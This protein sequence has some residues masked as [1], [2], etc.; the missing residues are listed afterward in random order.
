[1]VTLNKPDAGNTNWAGQVNS[2]WTSIE[3][4]LSGYRKRFWAQ[5]LASTG[6]GVQVFGSGAVTTEGSVVQTR[7]SDLLYYR[8]TTP[9]VA[10][11]DAGWY[12]PDRIE[13]RREWNP[14]FTAV[15]KSWVLDFQPRAWVGLF[16]GDPMSSATPSLH[17]AAFRYDFNYNNEYWYCVTDDGSGTPTISGPV[18]DEGGNDKHIFRIVMSPTD[19]K[20]YAGSTLVAT[21]TTHLPS[22]SQGLGPVVQARCLN[23]LPG[24]FGISKWE[25]EQD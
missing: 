23:A 15:L 16:S 25:L 1:M 8:Y 4:E 21:H 18:A 19:V 3:N 10:N 24:D 20:F 2:N 7:D 22:A 9:A 5:V 17:Y 13:T 6:T 14:G 11:S 12:L